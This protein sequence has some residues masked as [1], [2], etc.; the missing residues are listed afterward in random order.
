ML[1]YIHVYKKLMTLELDENSVDMFGIQMKQ[2]N[3]KNN[4]Q[5]W[6]LHDG[7]LEDK[8]IQLTTDKN[9]TSFSNGML[10]L[11]ATH[12]SP[13]TVTARININTTNSKAMST[14]VK[15]VEKAELES[16]GADFKRLAQQ[17]Y[18]LGPED[19]KNFEL[20]TYFRVTE[21]FDIHDNNYGKMTGYGRGGTHSDAGWPNACL[22]TCYKGV[23]SV[24]LK[25]TWFEKEYHHLSGST[26]YSDHIN[27]KKFTE[28]DLGNDGTNT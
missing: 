1:K 28:I 10:E 27:E 23:L 21:S 17:K 18:I 7:V 25:K 9:K 13:S 12:T 6:Y 22:A 2:K 5:E 19:F 26:G 8:R 16:G 15:E 4:G 20:T 11:Y 14:N 24:K 3:T